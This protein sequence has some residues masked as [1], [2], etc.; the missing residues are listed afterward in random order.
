MDQ[1]DQLEKEG[2]KDS[3]NTGLEMDD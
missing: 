2:K 1:Q 3:G